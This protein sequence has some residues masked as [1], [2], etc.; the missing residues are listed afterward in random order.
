MSLK[1]PKAKYFVRPKLSPHIQTPT[2]RTVN[3]CSSVKMKIIAQRNMY[4]YSGMKNIRNYNY[5]D[6]YEKIFI[7]IFK[8]DKKNLS[9]QQYTPRFITYV[10]NMYKV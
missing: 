6:K 8:S 1:K 5:V 10:E 9:K 4:L 3:T 2:I 7:P